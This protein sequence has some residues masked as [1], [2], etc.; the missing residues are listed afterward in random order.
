MD[1]LPLDPQQLRVVTHRA[2]TMRVRG[3]AGSGKSE[4]LRERFRRLVLGGDPDR[5]ALVLRSRRDRD[6]ARRDLHARLRTG[7]PALRVVTI[8]GLAFDVLGRHHAA[9]G[10]RQRPDL[11]P[12]PDQFARVRALLAEEDPAD[13]PA[14]GSLLGLRGFADHVRQFVLRAQESR[15]TP[16]EIAASAERA[17]LSG[18]LELTRFYRHYLDV[19]EGLGE[20]D[21]A[22]LVSRA[23]DAA[24]RVDPIYDHVMMDDAQ[25]TTEG[26][27]HLLLGLGA[28]STVVA[29]DEAAHVF[30]FQGTTVEPFRHLAERV[31]GTVDVVLAGDHRAS[32]RTIEAWNADHPS[33]EHAAV[34]RELRRIHAAGDVR[35]RDLAVVARRQGANLDGMVRA[36]DEARI[37]RHVPEGGVAF[38]AEPATLPYTLALTWIAHHERRD[39]LVDAVLTSRLGALSPAAARAMRRAA[40]RRGAPAAAAIEE[41]DGLTADEAAAIDALAATLAAAEGR[42]ANVADAFTELWRGLAHSARLVADDATATGGPRSAID[43]VLSLAEAIEDAASSD[44]P[45]VAAFVAALEARGDA[46]QLGLI[47]DSDADAVQVLT[48]H[49]AAGREFDTVIVIGAVEGDF[50]SVSRPEPMFDLDVLTRRRSQAEETA[51]RLADERRLY[52]MVLARARRRVLL[53][54]SDP[55]D[56]EERSVRTRFAADAAWIPAPTPSERDPVTVAEATASWRRTFADASATTRERAVALEGLLALGSRPDRWWYQRDWTSVGGGAGPDTMSFSRLKH[57]RTCDLRYVL[58]SELGLSPEGGFAANIGTIVH[59]VFEACDRGDID[60]TLEGLTAELERRWD[61]AAFPSRAVEEV[62]RRI[63]FDVMLPHWLA[64]YGDV[65]VLG[66]EVDFSFEIEGMRFNGRVDRIDLLDGTARIVDYKT[67]KKLPGL[68]GGAPGDDDLLQLQT[69]LVASRLAPELAHLPPVRRLE[70]AYVRGEKNHDR[71]AVRFLAFTDAQAEE[72]EATAMDAV[73]GLVVRVREL[74]ASGAY[75]PSTGTHCRGCEFKALCP[76]FEGGPAVP[77][78]G[79]VA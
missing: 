68:V 61:P 49:A 24:E 72:V 12:A 19:L 11:L 71:T 76:A 60:R 28:D 77:A 8:Q 40:R 44:D 36:L 37:P 34:A 50:P 58:A 64:T 4:A 57:L 2:G 17:G 70:V 56:D 54:A 52:D 26:A 42:A 46:P 18:W 33:E 67:G 74:A 55:G 5:V 6:E 39:D 45:S 78:D 66:V 27:L 73:R 41:R 43:A 29:G 47:R 9:L 7:L 79:V 13:W 22:G 62:E 53:T 1:P 14:Y 69:Y 3:G 23:A 32:A 31:R 30:S 25:D 59:A 48:A 65:P 15:R 75:R 16:E 51:E 35:W 10:Y 20:V 63:A 38:T 21:T